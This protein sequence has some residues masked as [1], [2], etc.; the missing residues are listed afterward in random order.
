[1]ASGFITLRNGKTWSPRWTGYDIVLK[2]IMNNLTDNEKE[3][4]LKK[5]IESILPNIENGDEECGYC[6]IRN[7]DGENVLREIDT[8]FIK[9]D[10]LVIFWNTLE[11]I[12]DEQKKSE[13]DFSFL[14]FDLFKEYKACLLEKNVEA[15]NLDEGKD[16]KYKPIGIYY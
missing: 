10:Y 9:N 5:W 8:R 2:T 3:F 13:N 12:V 16:I 6:F 15:K 1:M 4:E 7:S 14:F 11:K